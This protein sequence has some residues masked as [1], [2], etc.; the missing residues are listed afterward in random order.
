M[1]GC[2][3]GKPLP[4]PRILVADDD[5]AIRGMIEL[6]L[7]S[8]RFE[9]TTARDGYDAIELFRCGTFSL[10]ILDWQMPGLSGD[11]L[12]ELST[13][14]PGTKAIVVSADSPLQVRRA[15]SGRNMLMLLPKPFK[16]NDLVDAVKLALAR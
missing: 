7:R 4:V 1:P 3:A 5:C 13:I 2:Y 11:V 14:R 12:D 9:V 15:F 6:I 8:E 10:V 16:P